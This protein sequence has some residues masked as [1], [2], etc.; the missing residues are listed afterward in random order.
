[1]KGAVVILNRRKD[2]S[3]KVTFEQTLNSEG[4]RQVAMERK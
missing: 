2:F 3:E 1:M 4:G